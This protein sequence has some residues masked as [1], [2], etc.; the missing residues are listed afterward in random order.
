MISSADGEIGLGTVLADEQPKQNS[1]TSKVDLRIAKTRLRGL[2]SAE[3]L[4][5]SSSPTIDGI[6]EDDEEDVRQKERNQEGLIEER[7][8]KWGC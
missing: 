4:H 5:G 7:N 2:D 1:T 6:P 8:L 3:Q